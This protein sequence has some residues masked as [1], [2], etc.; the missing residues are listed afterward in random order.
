MVTV[1]LS[2]RSHSFPIHSYVENEGTLTERMVSLSWW[3]LTLPYPFLHAFGPFS[4]VHE[5]W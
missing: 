5:T 2:L 3:F 4:H 1:T